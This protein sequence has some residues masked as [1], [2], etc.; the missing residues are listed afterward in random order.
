[1]TTDLPDAKDAAE[2][3]SEEC[4]SGEEKKRVQVQAGRRTGLRG[5]AIGTGVP[6]RRPGGVR[7]EKELLAYDSDVPYAAFERANRAL[8][9]ALIDRQDRI[10]EELLLRINDMQYRQDDLELEL[11]NCAKK[12]VARKKERDAK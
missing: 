11:E 1:M 3:G 12:P 2:E 6:A 5:Q 9:G 7:A 10:T 4:G 8:F